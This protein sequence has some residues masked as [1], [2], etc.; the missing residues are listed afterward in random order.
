MTVA[1]MSAGSAVK[2]GKEKKPLKPPADNQEEILY[3]WVIT[4]LKEK[5]R[6]G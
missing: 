5:N 3:S 6:L 4:I 1:L 2:K